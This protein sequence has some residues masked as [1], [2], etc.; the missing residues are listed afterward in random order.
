MSD[1]LVVLAGAVGG[2][3]KDNESEKGEKITNCRGGVRGVAL[4]GTEGD[5]VP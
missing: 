4:R 3:T 1:Q 2:S 5:E